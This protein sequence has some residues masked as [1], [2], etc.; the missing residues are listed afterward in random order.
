MI[1]IALLGSTGSIGRQTID[2]V[3]AAPDRYKLV[4][5]AAGHADPAF[6]AQLREF[7]AALA[8]C[9]DGRP[10]DLAS[11]RWADGGLEQLGTT[12]GVDVVVVATTGMTA[13]PAVLAALGAGRR[14][15]LAN[16]EA[17]V[18]GG[19]LVRDALSGLGGERLDWLRPIDSEHSAIW[20]CLR[21]ER[22]EDVARLILTASGGP[23]RDRA[24]EDLAHVTPTE[25]LAHP[26]WQMGPKITIDSATLVNKAFEAIEARWLYDLP[27]PRIAAVLHPGSVVHSLVEF[28]DGSYKAQLGLPD[29]RLPIQYALSYPERHASP[30]RTAPPEDWEP[31]EFAALVPSRYP[32]Y[33]V[34]RAAAEAGGNRGA[35]L[36]AADEV[37]VSAFL[38]GALS[39]PEIAMTLE[40]A[41]DRWGNDT[42]PT[43]DQITELDAEVR[44][45]LS[46]EIG[47]EV[48]A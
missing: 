13:L 7:P 37:A 10:A 27:Y 23:F 20:Q 29:M 19:H 1:G 17:L 42:E 6:D 5:L 36:N 44:G 31:L 46:A 15:A 4:A 21:G 41:V 22:I 30:A 2:V 47:R 14:V 11:E 12:D 34:V 45:A 28:V 40:R 3:Q 33:A 9:A 8:W 38:A 18:T 32:A 35:V 16:K 24:P 43:A 26:T 48:R 25:A 39:F